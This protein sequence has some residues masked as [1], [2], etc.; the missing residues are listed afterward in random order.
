MA[1]F[2]IVAT[3]IASAAQTARNAM[4]STLTASIGTI[5][6]AQVR[7]LYGFPFSLLFLWGTVAITG[8]TVPVADRNFLAYAVSGA[9]LQIIGT[10]LMLAA[11][12]LRSFAVATAYL[13]TEPVLVALASVFVLEKAGQG[14]RAANRSMGFRALWCGRWRLFCL[15]GGIVSRRHPD[16]GRGSVLCARHDHVMLV[17]GHSVTDFDGLYA[18]LRPPCL[19]RQFAGVAAFAVCRI[20]GCLGLA[21]LVYRLF[22]VVGGQCTDFGT[23]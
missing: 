19:F 15:G 11:M 2:W 22:F 21:I 3:I 17:S 4:Q 18:D 1:S 23:G 14:R 7:F 16:F 20:H 10:V 12:R 13:K 8:E 5:G 9:V 6:A